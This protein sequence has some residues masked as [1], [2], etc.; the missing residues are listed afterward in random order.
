MLKEVELEI[1]NRKRTCILGEGA[2]QGVLTEDVSLRVKLR[3]VHVP[4]ARREHSRTEHARQPQQHCHLQAST[5]DQSNRA[6]TGGGKAKE[7]QFS[8]WLWFVRLHSEDAAMG[9]LQSSST[10]PVDWRERMK[11]KAALTCQQGVRYG[12]IGNKSS[13]TCVSG[14][15]RLTWGDRSL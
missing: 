11:S 1:S 9:A 13:Q 5:P 3:V 15:I 12:K 10:L 7:R 8:L 14:K 4:D 6:T 2:D